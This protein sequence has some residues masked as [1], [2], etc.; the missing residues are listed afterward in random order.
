MAKSVAS[1]LLGLGL[2]ACGP[3]P[4][5]HS[6]EVDGLL[7]DSDHVLEV[8]DLAFN[9]ALVRDVMGRQGPKL[10]RADFDRILGGVSIYV[11]DATS[12]EGCG[13]RDVVGCTWDLSGR[14]ELDRTTGSLSHE[15][16]HVYEDRTGRPF[17]GHADWNERGYLLVQFLYRTGRLNPSGE[18]D[19]DR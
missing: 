14:I 3:A 10:S 12:W 2:V 11:H 8:E 17:N 7:F 16:L 1:L 9:V 5:V 13:G 19:I 15:L 18:D 6:W 4:A